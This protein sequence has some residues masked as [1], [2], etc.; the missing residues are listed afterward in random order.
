MI[1]DLRRFESFVSHEIQ[2]CRARSAMHFGW[3]WVF[4]IELLLCNGLTDF[5]SFDTQYYSETIMYDAQ[6]NVSRRF[7]SEKLMIMVLRNCCRVGIT[8]SFFR[9]NETKIHRK[10]A[11]RTA[12][13]PDE[14]IEEIGDHYLG[15]ITVHLTTAMVS[16]VMIIIFISKIQLV[17]HHQCCVLIGWASTRLY[18]IAH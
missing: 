1:T 4:N 15:W 5:V 7:S 17:V 12:D 11:I 10:S 8:C 18:V 9:Q 3:M 16:I 14:E 6:K 2:I 13:L